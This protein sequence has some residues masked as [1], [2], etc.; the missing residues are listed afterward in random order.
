MSFV[1]RHISH[2][3]HKHRDPKK[4]LFLEFPL[5][6]ALATILVFMWSLG[7][8]LVLEPGHLSLAKSTKWGMSAV[9][10]SGFPRIPPWLSYKKHRNPIP[11][12]QDQSKGQRIRS[13][14][15]LAKRG[16]PL[17]N[18]FLEVSKNQGPE[19]RPQILSLFVS[20]QTGPRFME[21]AIW[22]PIWNSITY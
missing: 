12:S 13:G 15:W 19:N 7:A 11:D 3:S 5:S 4:P 10:S 2:S 16:C 14:C 20:P 17:R 6:Q 8:L 22:V 9:P 1:T 21:E 18:P